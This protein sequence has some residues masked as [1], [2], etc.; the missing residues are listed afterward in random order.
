M[1]KR[2]LVISQ[3]FYPEQFRIND[4][5]EQWVKRGYD[6]TVVTAIPNYPQGKFY[7]GY[8]ITKNRME[9]YKGM[10]IVR[11]P[12]VPRGNNPIML[13][14]NYLSFII[15]GFFWSKLTKLDV[16]YVFN[17][18]TSP[19]TQSLLGVWYSKR[20]KKPY[21]LYIQDLWPENV[22]SV[23]GVKNK[24]I[25]NLIGKMVDYIYSNST[26]VLATS[27]SMIEAIKS[28][29]V[30]QSKLEYFPQYAEEFYKPVDVNMVEN[31]IKDT[32]Y[33]KNIHGRQNFNLIFTGNIGYA[34]G[35]DILPKV[36]KILKQDDLP[37]NVIFN[38]IGDGRYKSTLIK[39]VK[40]LNVEDMFNFIDRQPA[41]KI[42]QYMSLSDVA[43]LTLSNNK[44]FEMTIPAKLQ[45]YI[46][47]AM[48]IIASARGETENIIKESNCGI[49]V[50][51]GDEIAFAK[52]VK[53][54]MFLEKKELNKLGQ[55]GMKYSEENFNRELLL[56]QMDLNFQ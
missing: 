40:E 8:G 39:I 32:I 55:N 25:L 29:N 50:K 12:I 17:F 30:P 4:I 24:F 20:K 19:I 48:P 44:V 33:S 37:K 51:N 23:A 3:C 56:N 49:C 18:E 11:L 22:E 27:Q 15:S 45:S 47:C 41:E 16:D 31:K 36:A 2:V 10:K 42:P 53:Q 43:V 7:D 1:K 34:Q 54:L 38:M 21:Y 9:Y 28:R 5:T 26:K 35:L 52:A 46:A 13:C 14:L 6:I